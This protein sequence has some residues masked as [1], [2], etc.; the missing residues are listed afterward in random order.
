MDNAYGASVTA[1]AA[2]VSVCDRIDDLDRAEWSTVVAA[3]QAPVFYDYIFLRAYER[4]PLQQTEAFFYLRFGDP[5]VAVLP[6]YIQ[7]T[8][9][10]LGAV[11]SLG[12]PGRSP[13][14]LILQTHV[15]H[16]YDTLIPARP[17]VLTPRLVGQAC[18]TLGTLATQAGLKW[19]AFLNVDGSSELADLLLSA[20]LMKLPIFTRHNKRIAD[21]GSADEFVAGIPS[22]KARYALRYSYR[23]AQQREMRVT[24]PDPAG[25]VPAA[26]E[27]C[28]RITARHGTAAYYPEWFGEF[29]TLAAE[30]VSVIEVRLAGELAFATIC[31]RDPL[32]FHMWAGGHDYR[33]MEGIHS[34]FP[35]ILLSAVEKAIENRYPIFEA[36]RAN[37]VVKQRYRLEP[38]PL[39]AFV[40]ET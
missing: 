35:L 26:V 31:L 19:F 28:Q 30:V 21:Y 34:A 16:C 4:L 24:Y 9:D 20:G 29:V 37:D 2:Q 11:S 15:A 18:E 33:V 14:D 13:G 38:R 32:R 6:A 23:Q 10:P 12:L 40:A 1:D 27:L 17:G 39:F 5:A 36:G 22:H 25:G 7:S 8:D 3:A